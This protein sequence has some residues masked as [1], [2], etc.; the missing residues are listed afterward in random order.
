VSHVVVLDNLFGEKENAEFLRLVV[1]PGWDDKDGPCP[2]LWELGTCDADGLP[3]SWGLKS[4]LLTKLL[5]SDCEAIVEVQTRLQQLY[6]EYTIAHVDE[7][8]VGVGVGAGPHVVN[9][10]VCGGDYRWHIDADPR[11]LNGFGYPNREPGKPYFVTMLI[12]INEG[13][14]TG[15][16][17]ET[18]FLDM[19]SD[20]GFFVR[21]AQF[22]TILMD[23]DIT[24]RMSA[25]SKLA[26]GKPRYS[27][28]WKLLFVPK[29]A[30]ISPSIAKTAWGPP[31]RLGAS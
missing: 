24:H 12:Y 6:P 26:N 7:S 31:V 29:D 25:P 11:M 15:W 27:L 14:P 19:E 4:A 17:A 21:P 2:D 5:D 3:P 8:A 9:A 20:T 13:W 16:D 30:A 1:S 23:Q 10:A 18:F 28:V 22:R